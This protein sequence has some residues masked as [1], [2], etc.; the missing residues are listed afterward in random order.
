V[1]A[2]SA[3]VEISVST[4]HDRGSCEWPTHSC[5]NFAPDEPIRASLAEI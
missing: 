3:G 1:T 2:D 4:E 5:V